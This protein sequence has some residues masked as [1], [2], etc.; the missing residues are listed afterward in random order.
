MGR[1]RKLAVL[2]LLFSIALGLV[3]FTAM[4]YLR[5]SPPTINFA[6]GHQPGEPVDLNLQTVGT[7]GFGT[8]PSWVSYMAEGS[9][10]NWVHTTLW[11]LPAHTRINVTIFEYD[12]GSPLRNQFFGQVSGTIGGT[13]TLNGKVT[14]LVNSNAGNGVAHTFTVPD[15]GIDVPL[16]GVNSNAKNICSEAPCSPAKSAHNIIKFSFETPGPGQYPWQCSLPCGLGYLYGTGGPMQSIGYM[17][18]FL[19]VVA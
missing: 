12:T 1:S 17:D 13:M 18:G 2:G 4:A 3:V 5:S 11:D 16:W 8:H 14:S 6:A 7:I 10:G 19:K 15:L 9:E